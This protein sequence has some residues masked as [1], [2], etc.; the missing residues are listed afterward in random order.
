MANT[1][2]GASVEVEFESVG[3]LRKALKEATS[4]V[5]QMQEKFGLASEEAV[6]ASK[7]LA[8]LKDTIK[9]A[10]EQAALFDPGKKFQAFVNLGSTIA[11]GFSAVQGAMALV[12]AESEDVQ[13]SLMKVQAAM[14]LAQGLSELKEFGKAWTGVKIL[15]RDATKG[16]NLF[17]KAMLGLGIGILIAVVAAWD[18][19]AKALGFAK[20]QSEDYTAAQK[21]GNDALADARAKVTEVGAA[22]RAAEKDTKLKEAALKTYNESLGETIGRANTLEEAERLFRE[23]TAAYLAAVK[24]RAISQEAF[25]R[26]AKLMVDY[27]QGLADLGVTSEEVEN[28]LKAT[29][30]S[31]AEFVLEIA[32]SRASESDIKLAQAAMLKSKYEEANQLNKIAEDQLIIAQQNEIK[33]SKEAELRNKK[34]AETKINTAK[35][36]ND[37]ETKLAQQKEEALRLIQETSLKLISEKDAELEKLRLQNIQNINKLEVAGFKENS[38]EREDLEKAYQNERDAIKKKYQDEANKKQKEFEE[39]LNAI[40]LETQ[41]AGIINVR[42]KEIEELKNTYAE[43][44]KEIE[45]N[46]NYNH[47]QSYLLRAALITQQRQAEKALNEKFRQEDIKA[48][49]DKL[50]KIASNEKFNFNERLTALK[51]HLDLANQLTFESEDERKAYIEK[52]TQ[53]IIKLQKDEKQHRIDVENAKYQAVSQSISAISNLVG[54]FAS[55]NEK[56]AKKMFNIQKALNISQAIIDTYA[57]ANS[58]FRQASLNPATVLFPAQPFIAAGV[59]IATGLANVAKISQQKFQGGNSGGGTPPPPTG[60]GGGGSPMQPALSTAVQGQALNAEAINNLGNQSLR[61]YVMNSDI[62]NNNQRNAYLQRNARL[63]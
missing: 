38:K 53:D 52:I 12:G 5:I 1:V 61:A 7:K 39:K 33:Y 29:G 62:Q 63:G 14:A 31:A 15:I 13:K 28:R 59:A 10:G 44:L 37:K 56:Q 8:G 50:N 46:E 49:A 23:N 48:E 58:I 9:E 40:E 47:K 55:D 51:S 21:A 17:G 26:G 35:T 57:A 54:A 27:E 16:L 2:I 19:I 43:K 41:I 22:F 42:E 36:T 32:T 34:H 24:A 30:K 60:L 3:G 11:A 45:T 6:A 20:K 4:E 25:S 18:D